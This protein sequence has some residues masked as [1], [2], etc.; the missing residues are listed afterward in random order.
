MALPLV[1]RC[2]WHIQKPEKIKT[3]SKLHNVSF[4]LSLIDSTFLSG[5]KELSLYRFRHEELY[6]SAYRRR[7]LLMLCVLRRESARER[8]NSIRFTFTFPSLRRCGPMTKHSFCGCEEIFH[9][10]SEIKVR[11]KARNT[12]VYFFL[13]NGTNIPS[14]HRIYC[15]QP[16]SH[17]LNT[18]LNR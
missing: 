9:A 15:I 4:L 14:L 3:K 2:R 5:R 16:S 8:G 18:K 10:E 12:R 6:C 13:D 7:L 11:S 17:C 1:N